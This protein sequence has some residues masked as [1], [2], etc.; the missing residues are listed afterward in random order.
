MSLI[1]DILSIAFDVGKFV[2]EAISNGDEQVWRPIADILP[3][4]LKSRLERVA[5]DAK[6]KADLEDILGKDEDQD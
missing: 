5:Q 6:M 3:V 1:G 2:A 4:P